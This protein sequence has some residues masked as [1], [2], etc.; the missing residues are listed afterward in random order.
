MQLVVS[1]RLQFKFTYKLKNPI[2][3]K[4]PPK[5]KTKLQRFAC[6]VLLFFKAEVTG[7]AAVSARWGAPGAAGFECIKGFISQAEREQKRGQ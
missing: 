3:P 5:R 2:P 1:I 6:I 4:P 7:G